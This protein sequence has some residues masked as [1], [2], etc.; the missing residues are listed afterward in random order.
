MKAK[1]CTLDYRTMQKRIAITFFR[2]FLIEKAIG[3]YYNTFITFIFIP[4]IQSI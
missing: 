4:K 2:K 1:D 3:R